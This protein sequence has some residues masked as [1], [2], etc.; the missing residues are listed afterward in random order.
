MNYLDS[1]ILLILFIK[2]S[3]SLNVFL[4]VNNTSY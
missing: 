1:N 3:F 2:L 4:E